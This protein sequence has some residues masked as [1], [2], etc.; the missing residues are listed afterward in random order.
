MNLYRIAAIVSNRTAVKF[1]RAFWRLA[2]EL[3][4][5]IGRSIK[6]LIESQFDGQ[7]LDKSPIDVWKL[8]KWKLNGISGLSKEEHLDVV[9][10][11]LRYLVESKHDYSDTAKTP[12]GAFDLF[13]Y[14]IKQR[15]LSKADQL[16]TRYRMEKLEEKGVEEPRADKPTRKQKL[17]GQEGI[18]IKEL[19]KVLDEQV[20]IKKFLDTLDDV[21]PD[22]ISQLPFDQAA[23]FDLIFYEDEGTFKPDI[24]ANNA[25]ATRFREFLGKMDTP[26]AKQI[27]KKNQKR[28][29]GYVGDTRKKLLQN[30]QEFI[31]DNLT[32]KEYDIFYQTFFSDTTPAE[33]EKHEMGIEA[34]K[35]KEA[36]EKSK[37]KL[38]RYKKKELEGKLTPR[39]K[40]MYRNLEKKLQKAGIGEEEEPVTQRLP[41]TWE[42]EPITQRLPE[43]E[44][45]PTT[46]RWTSS[47]LSV[48][49]ARIAARI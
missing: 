33:V 9:Q 44:E 20:D 8:V 32:E 45:E 18:S 17:R 15:G 5:D 49:A 25:Q 39:E 41:D 29:S 13:L 36:L 48:I 10:D 7:T 1:I 31:N 22:L 6:E 43:T 47:A 37:R 40:K 2:R 27:L 3:E 11:F 24:Q 34:E 21:I 42:E 46:Q 19:T 38:E 14:N 16:H 35:E 23:L 30:I 12:K 4:E 28:W 26:E